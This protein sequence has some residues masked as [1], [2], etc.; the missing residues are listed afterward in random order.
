LENH[1]TSKTLT[2]EQRDLVEEFL[3]AYNELDSE[4]RR[5]LGRDRGEVF[6]ARLVNDFNVRYPHSLDVGYLKTVGGLRNLLVHG[7]KHPYEYVAVPSKQW[8]P[9]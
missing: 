2:K 4:L 8:W 3:A 5:S 1:N 6:F 9:I 7:T